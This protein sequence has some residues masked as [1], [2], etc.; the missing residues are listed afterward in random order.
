LT[1]TAFGASS[2]SKRIPKFPCLSKPVELIEGQGRVTSL[3]HIVRFSDEELKLQALFRR[4]DANDRWRFA[5]GYRVDVY[6]N[7]VARAV[8]GKRQLGGKY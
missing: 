8:L 7:G 4:I 5:Y 3:W 1:S 2:P 6:L